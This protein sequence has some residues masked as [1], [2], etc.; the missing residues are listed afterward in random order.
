MAYNYS[1]KWGVG[2]ESFLTAREVLAVSITLTFTSY[3][4]LVFVVVIVITLLK[5]H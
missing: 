4:M 1:K 5:K 2:R 3:K